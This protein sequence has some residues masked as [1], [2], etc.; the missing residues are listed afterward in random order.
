M[1]KA[2]GAKDVYCAAT[3]GVLSRDALERIQNSEVKEFVV[4]NTIE[5]SEEKKAK[6]PKLKVLS[7]AT[8][9]A[10]TIESIALETPVSNVY[11]LFHQDK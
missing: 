8:L 4:T 10:R 11:N 6:C 7:V 1:L 9:L 5:L 2:H 3:H